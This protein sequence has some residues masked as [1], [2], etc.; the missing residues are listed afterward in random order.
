[1][2]QLLEVYEEYILTATFLLISICVM[3]LMFEISLFVI[4]VCM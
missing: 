1:M 2:P 3:Y 4:V